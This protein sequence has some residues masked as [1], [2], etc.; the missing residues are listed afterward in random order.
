MRA[1]WTQ[2]AYLKASN[3][4]G[5]DSFGQSV[6]ISGDTI[7]IGEDG[8]DSDSDIVNGDQGDVFSFFDAG[9]AYVFTRNGSNWSLEAYLKASSSDGGDNFGWSVDVSD[10]QVVVGAMYGSSD[11]DVVDGGK[12]NN[13]AERSGA[14]YLFSLEK[15]R[16][17]QTPAVDAV[18]FWG[19]I[20]LL[21]S[22]FI[23]A[24]WKLRFR[25]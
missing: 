4:D 14:T 21:G 16:G 6:A 23:L 13:D 7:V 5:G 2:Q 12:D 3:S 9:A 18:S 19:L 22:V 1:T 8:E 11:S 20:L 15:S 25:A 17:L 10:D 24:L